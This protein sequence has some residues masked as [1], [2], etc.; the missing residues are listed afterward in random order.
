M[1][2]TVLGHVVKYVYWTV[3][4]GL[5]CVLMSRWKDG[6]HCDFSSRI[7][8]GE[9]YNTVLLKRNTYHVA[10]DHCNNNYSCICRPKNRLFLSVSTV[11]P[12]QR[13]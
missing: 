10:A 8:L 9:F 3:S 2:V 13:H 6:R 11:T 1:V 5:K 7:A 4:V 12:G